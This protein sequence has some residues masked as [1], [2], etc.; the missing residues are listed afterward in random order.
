MKQITLTKLV[1]DRPHLK[2]RLWA[3]SQ[4]KVGATHLV[5]FQNIT[6]DSSQ[7][8]A[9]TV[10][11]IGPTMT[12]KTLAE[13]EGRHLHDLPSQRQYPQEFVDLAHPGEGEA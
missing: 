8:G 2:D 1:A 5:V 6:M 3:W 7:F 11:A 12:Y 9:E 13:I 4:E 10:V